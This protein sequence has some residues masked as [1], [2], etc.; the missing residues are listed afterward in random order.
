[1]NVVK[2]ALYLFFVLSLCTVAAALTPDAVLVTTNKPW[3]IAGGTETSTITVLV[4]NN[5]DLSQPV[6]GA[7]VTAIVDDPLMGSI[8]P[9]SQTVGDASQS[10]TFTFRPKTKSGNASVTVSVTNEGVTKTGHGIQPVDHAVPAAYADLIYPTNATVDSTVKIQVRL[11][12]IYNNII[13]GKN[14]GIQT[15]ENIVFLASPDSKG[16]W[17]A[18]VFLGYKTQKYINETGYATVEYR[19]STTTALNTIQV[20]ANSIVSSNLQWVT[21]QGTAAKP[22][23]ITSSITS[24]SDT[25]NTEPHTALANGIDKFNLYYTVYDT[26]N[27]PVPGVFIQWSSSEGKSASY[28]TNYQGV[29]YLQYGPSDALKDLAITA[30]T[31]EISKTD[32]VSFI[33][34]EPVFFDLSANPNV[35]AS[36]E[37]NPTSIST[38][39]VRLLDGMGLPVRGKNVQFNF[40]EGRMGNSTILLQPP[41]F[42]DSTYITTTSVV[43]DAFGF[44]TVYVYPGRFPSRDEFGYEEDATGWVDISAKWG[45]IQKETTVIY[46][47]YPFL[48]VQTSVEPDT[49]NVTEPVDITIQLIGDGY[50]PYKPIDL[51][52]S[53]HRG[54]SIFGD[55]YDPS[56]GLSQD[57]M[58]SLRDAALT[59]SPQ[60]RPRQDRLGIVTFGINGTTVIPE[61]ASSWQQ[62]QPGPDNGKDSDVAWAIGEYYSPL[63]NYSDYATL[64]SGLTF[65]HNLI[66]E[67]IDGMIP[68]KDPGGKYIVTTRYGLYKAIKELTR[69]GASPP[70]P[71]YLGYSNMSVKAVILFTDIQWTNFGDP[72]AGWNGVSVNSQGMYVDEIPD[73]YNWPQSGVGPWAAFPDLGNLSS[74]Q[75]NLANYAIANKVRVYAVAYYP[76]NS[77]IDK[78]REKILRT[79]SEPT[80]GK[81]YLADNGTALKQIFQDILEEMKIFASVGTSMNISVANVSV[82]YNNITNVASGHE[83]FDYVYL[84]GHSTNISSWNTS[85]MISG[86]LLT[87]SGTCGGLYPANAVPLLDSCNTTY[88]YSINQTIDWNNNNLYFYVGNISIKQTWQSVFTLIAKKPGSI[89]LFGNN[90]FISYTNDD[91]QSDVNLP[92]PFTPITVINN[93]LPGPTSQ[94][95]LDIVDG[96]LSASP[97]GS[98]E[99]LNVTWRVNYTGN[100]TVKQLIYYQFSRDGEIWS[101][102]W[103]QYDTNSTINRN[104]TPEE[105][106]Q[107]NFDARDREGWIKFKVFAFEEPYGGISDTE[108]TATPI[109]I[110]ALKGNT[111]KIS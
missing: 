16:F 74:S 41:S 54:E 91:M 29:I 102:D 48:R 100:E 14:P 58:V 24:F 84:Q 30:R 45:N 64:D 35:I 18:G 83:L 53:A 55:M 8:S 81:F 11:K 73:D 38:V 22:A 101:N 98:T 75:Q 66:N 105:I 28:T 61:K 36:L 1:M 70:S 110:A 7:V 107:S 23:K 42:N 65:D 57:K 50:A 109:D 12:D 3:V 15:A 25:N 37:A 46:K 86:P 2:V 87:S 72:S 85:G 17:D 95:I 63:K 27:N 56:T 33:S 77:N 44:A 59:I 4:R 79:I 62:V 71:G 111:I 88:P 6:T 97:V 19:M 92:L 67:N 40:I 32:R 93:T 49:V 10:V 80:G 13:D 108:I 94:M 76:E 106:F 21:I 78:T 68:S 52:L 89:D 5:T 31:G 26:F 96:S 69:S 103:I 34:G 43:S 39:Y 82:T 51:V 99:L 47:N 104:I 20:I 90:S 60:L 9:V